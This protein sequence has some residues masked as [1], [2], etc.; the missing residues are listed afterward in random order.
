MRTLVID[1]VQIPEALIAR[2]AQNHPA[3]DA[4]QAWAEAA[5]AL[6]VR[7]LLLRRAHQLDLE[8]EPDVDA[9]GREETPEEAL[10]RAVLD[11]EVEFEPPSEA[12]CRRVYDSQASRFLAPG[13]LEASHILVGPAPGETFDEARGLA[14]ARDLIAELERA[15]GRFAELAKAASAC[16]SASVGGSLGQL[17]P[18]DLV[19]EVEAALAG[20]RPGETSREPVKSRF[21][22]HVLR[23]DRRIEGRKLPFERVEPSI[24]LN[25]EGRAWTAAAAR[26]VAGLAEEA[27]RTGLI[28]AT[29]GEAPGGGATLGAMLADDAA[30]GRLTAWLEIAD[31]ALLARAEAAAAAAG[32]PLASWICDQANSFVATADDE[33]WTQLVSA[34][35]GAEDPALAGLAAILKRTLIAEPRRFTVIQRKA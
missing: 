11:L 5:H 8:P 25:L 2:E 32:A 23:L 30:A 33:A 28:V 20:L 27:R 21:G 18:G 12:E 35:Q 10:I 34:A 7:A 6:A 15:P 26:Y 19:A 9:E 22:W 13:L 24:R 1:G 16:P 14:T 4:G 31:P 3:A 17:T 29:D